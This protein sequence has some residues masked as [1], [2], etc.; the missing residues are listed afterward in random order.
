MPVESQVEKPRAAAPMAR[1]FSA[2]ATA[3]LGAA[4]GSLAAVSTHDLIIIGAGSGNSILTPDFDERHL[5]V[6]E[7]ERRRN[8]EVRGIL[9]IQVTKFLPNVITGS[10]ENGRL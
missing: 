1:G 9:N 3:R 7:I 4:G 6:V 5:P 8:G 2:S 10:G